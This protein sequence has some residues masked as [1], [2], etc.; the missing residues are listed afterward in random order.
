MVK[1]A[2]IVAVATLVLIALLNSAPPIL[3]TPTAS[4][5]TPGV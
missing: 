5:T 1:D 4:Q 3:P 2:V